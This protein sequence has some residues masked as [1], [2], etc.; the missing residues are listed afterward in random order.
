MSDASYEIIDD[1][2]DTDFFK[3]LDNEFPSTLGSSTEIATLVNQYHAPGS[4][5]Y[6]PFMFWEGWHKKPE[7]TV[8]KKAIRL[9]W[10]DRLPCAIEDV[11]GFE[12]WVRTFSVGQF[13]N[14]HVDE[15]TFAY[16]EDK[17]FNAPIYGC[18]Y[19]GTTDKVVDGELQLHNSVIEGSPI[20]VLERNSLIQLS[21][22]ENDRVGI[23]HIGN[24]AIFFDAGRRLHNTA[25]ATSGIRKVLVVNVWHKDSPP[26]GLL[27]GMFA[28]E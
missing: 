14:V 23:K 2:F 8:L 24:R 18:V 19:Y 22:P 17:S 9:L 27:K 13:L 7:D 20:G 12:Y 28:Y 5:H 26:R 3:Q 1:F 21:T 15:D 25:P 6:A 16:E 11:C 4:E 10:E